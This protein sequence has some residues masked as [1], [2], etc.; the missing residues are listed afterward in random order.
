MSFRNTFALQNPIIKAQKFTDEFDFFGSITHSVRKIPFCMA[1]RC[2]ATNFQNIYIY[3]YMQYLDIAKFPPFKASKNTHRKTDV[4]LPQKKKSLGD[5]CFFLKPRV[6]LSSP[7]YFEVRN[8]RV[9]AAAS[10]CPSSIASRI[11][12][13]WRFSLWN[14][15]GV[16]FW[17]AWEMTLGTGDLI[18]K[19]LG[20]TT[21]K[22]WD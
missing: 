19:W 12:G 1:P 3:T 2:G 14:P 15:S 7:R 9:V 18:K 21:K 5:F 22:N 11:L 10:I 17:G 13:M 4:S 16:R 6:V 8:T 20:G